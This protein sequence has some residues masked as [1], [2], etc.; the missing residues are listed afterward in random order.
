MS[1]IL[2]KLLYRYDLELVSTDLDWEVSCKMHVNWLKPAL[3]VN[4][5]ERSDVHRQ[6]RVIVQ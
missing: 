5:L 6:E 2:S 3:N 1:L 4:F